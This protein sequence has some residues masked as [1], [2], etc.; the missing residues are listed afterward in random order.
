MFDQTCQSHYNDTI[1]LHHDPQ[2]F[3]D[4]LVDDEAADHLAN[5]QFLSH[6]K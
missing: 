2:V 5:Q 4:A 6:S 1:A 3:V